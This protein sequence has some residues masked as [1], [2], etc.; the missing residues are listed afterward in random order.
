MK[1]ILKDQLT[2]IEG[3]L[4]LLERHSSRRAKDKK[5]RDDGTPAPGECPC[6]SDGEHC[7]R[8]H[9]LIIY[10]LCGE[11]IP[12]TDEPRITEILDPIGREALAWKEVED[13]VA[14]GMT[15]KERV[16]YTWARTWRKKIEALSVSS[17]PFAVQSAGVA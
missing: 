13:S 4:L 12:M 8:K 16:P 11:T 17:C 14:C 7:D 5:Q 1:P 2:E 15:V 3:E 9:L 10:K 6:N